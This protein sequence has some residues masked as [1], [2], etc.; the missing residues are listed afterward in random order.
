[1]Q[2]IHRIAAP[3]SALQYKRFSSSQGEHLLVLQHSRLFD[4]PPDAAIELDSNPLELNRLAGVLG[5][6]RADEAALDLVVEPPAQSLSLNVSSSCNLACSYCY[7]DRGGFGGK[8]VDR[9][10]PETAIAAVDQLFEG[11]DRSA[12]VTIGFLG[13]EPLLN[14]TLVH[15]V[16]AHAARTGGARG[17]DVRFSITTNGTTLTP[18]DINLFRANRFAVTVS[19][20][21]GAEVQEAEAASIALQSGSRRCL[22]SPAWLR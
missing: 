14:R 16:V 11:A 10:T 8:Q 4:L 13:G 22:P 12:P 19:I 2:I 20:D 17:L 1:M 6:T 7:A 21:G 3:A 15:A 9:M 5:E 18:L